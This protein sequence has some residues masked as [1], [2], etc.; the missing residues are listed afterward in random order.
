MI[1]PTL[2]TDLDLDDVFDDLDLLNDARAYFDDEDNDDAPEV[3]CK[4]YETIRRAVLLLVVS[5]HLSREKLAQV[6]K[7]ARGLK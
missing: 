1:D 7:L 2:P 3:I 4:D 6:V 5:G